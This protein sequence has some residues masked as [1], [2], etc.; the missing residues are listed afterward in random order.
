ME[1]D[2]SVLNER[3]QDLDYLFTRDSK[4]APADFVPDEGLK[5]M[6]FDMAK[7]LVIGAG[8]LG[9]EILKDLALSGFR[10][11]TVID[12]DTIDVTNLNRQF[13]FR[14]TDIGKYKA[15]CAADFIQNRCEGVKVTAHT[16]MIQDFDTEFYDQFHVIIAGLDNIE[17]RRWLNAQ[18]HSMVK[19][20]DDSNVKLETVKPFIDGGT[21]GFRGQARLIMPFISGC[22]ECTL[23]SLPKQ[24]S[25]PMCTIAETPRLPEHCIQHAYVIQWPEHFKDKKV[26]KDSPDD[27]TWIYERAADRAD[28]YGIQGVTYSLTMGVVKNIIPAIASTNALVSAACVNEAVKVATYCNK[29]IDNYYMFMGQSSVYTQTFRFDKDDTCIVCSSHR[30]SQT[31]S[32]TMKLNEFRDQLIEKYSLKNPSLASENKGSLYIP[33]PL[34]KKLKAR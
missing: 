30:I 34:A 12:M 21:E 23:A 7:V 26:D 2:N 4:F 32:K 20:D 24:M 3:F 5:S 1:G 9:C 33:G 15:Q 13:L 19:F 27:M 16:N 22:F 14:K 17:A 31:V 18:L 25:Y 10:D 6:L 28:T 11:I 29:S 8:G